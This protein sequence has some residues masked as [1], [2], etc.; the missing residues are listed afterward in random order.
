M[1]AA[2]LAAGRQPRHRAMDLLIAATAADFGATLVTLNLGDFAG[3]EDFVPVRSPTTL[4]AEPD[5][6]WGEPPASAT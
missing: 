2:V 4:N 1:G 6:T 5:D 3:L